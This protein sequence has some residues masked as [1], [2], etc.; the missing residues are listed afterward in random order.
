MLLICICWSNLANAQAWIYHPFPYVNA[1]WNFQNV[2]YS[3]NGNWGPCNGVNTNVCYIDYRYRFSGDTI[4][5]GQKYANVYCD[6]SYLQCP[7]GPSQHQFVPAGYVGGI[8]NDTLNKRVYAIQ[9][10]N[11]FGTEYLLYDFNWLVGDTFI[12]CN[13]HI[14]VI[15]SVLIG[16]NYRKRFITSDS[17]KF[18]EGIGNVGIYNNGFS[19]EFFW[20]A[21]GL[22][23]SPNTIF[24]CYTDSTENYILDSWNCYPYILS[25]IEI[26]IPNPGI[27][28]SPNPFTSLTTITFDETQKNTSLTV[29]D[30]L[31]NII[32]QSTIINQQS[33]TIDMS[34]YAKGVYFVRIVS[35][36][37]TTNVVNRK[38]V[39]N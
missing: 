9:Y 25:S 5:A 2:D 34:G 11:G 39:K 30:V 13:N 1:I 31:G 22:T 7:C 3:P 21:C 35:A 20:S 26:P 12:Q 27:R 23:M 28:I 37:S 33:K 15:D 10:A 4:V 32:L 6:V 8:R 19:A 29:T 24:I 36:G 17:S 38:M 16:S 18:I 14:A